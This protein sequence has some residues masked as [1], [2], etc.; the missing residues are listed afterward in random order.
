MLANTEM[1]MKRFP[2]ILPSN[3]FWREGSKTIRSTPV[4][5]IS[6]PIN[7]FLFRVSFKKSTEKRKIKSGAEL[8]MM[9]TFI[10][11]VFWRDKK[12]KPMFTVIPK[13]VMRKKRRKSFD[14]IWSCL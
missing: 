4:K 5:P 12:K 13:N 6:A 9:G 14:F 7:F 1:M 11:S 8:P 10:L 3:P 2:V